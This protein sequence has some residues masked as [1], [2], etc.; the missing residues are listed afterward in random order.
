MPCV[1]W[2]ATR[3]GCCP[4]S[5]RAITETTAHVEAGRTTLAGFSA[6][7]PGSWTAVATNADTA[8]TK[9]AAAQ[10]AV[11]AAKAAVAAN[12]RDEAAKQ[13][14]AAENALTDADTLLAAIDATAKGLAEMTARLAAAMAEEHADLAKAE[15]AVAS[16]R[17]KGKEQ[18]LADAKARLAQA[19]QLSGATPPDVAGATRLVTEADALLDQVMADVERAAASAQNAIG[20]GGHEHRP[21]ARPGERAA[22]VA[23]AR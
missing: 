1:T 21:G 2:A 16:G 23:G 20:D 12:K 13:A 22:R 9:V 14:R 15:Q 10:T 3:S 8:A 5:R 19:A 7:A 17:A 18:Q 11:D 6:Y 4:R